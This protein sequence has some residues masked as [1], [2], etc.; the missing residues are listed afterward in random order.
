ML[1][2]HYFTFY[3][4]APTSSLKG[5]KEFIGPCKNENGEDRELGASSHIE[6]LVDCRQ[7]CDQKP[8]CGAFSWSSDSKDCLLTSSMAY[9]NDWETAWQCFAKT[10]FGTFKSLETYKQPVLKILITRNVN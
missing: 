3:L 9:T 1:L 4:H 5:Y 6:S 2:F 7:M 8:G 10:I